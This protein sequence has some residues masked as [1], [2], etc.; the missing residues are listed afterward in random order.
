MLMEKLSNIYLYIV[1]SYLPI[2][3]LLITLCTLTGLAVSYMLGVGVPG[4]LFPFS[5]VGQ[6]A[7][8]FQ[9]IKIPY[10]YSFN[11]QL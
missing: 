4:Q 9:T 6:L 10:T 11:K 1:L 2:V 5:P 7:R 8:L 3:L